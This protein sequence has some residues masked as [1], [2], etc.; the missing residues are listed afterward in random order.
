L[1][2]PRLRD[3]YYEDLRLRW[4]QAYDE[5]EL[6][7]LENLYNGLLS[8]QNVNGALQI[9]QAQKLCKISLNIDDKIR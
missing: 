3:T 8:S 9:D 6:V 1:E 4:G 5:E 2:I 7:Y